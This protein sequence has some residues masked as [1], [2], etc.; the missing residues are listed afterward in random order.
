MIWWGLLVILWAGIRLWNRR[1]PRPNHQK[2]D[3]E[4]LL[5][6]ACVLHDD[7]AKVEMSFRI[8]DEIYLYDEIYRLRD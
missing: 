7:E 6:A 4:D 8:L 3:D 5:I 2:M 1:G